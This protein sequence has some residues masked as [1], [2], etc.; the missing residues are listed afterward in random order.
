MNR[1]DLI[2]KRNDYVDNFKQFE[3]IRILGKNI[4]SCKISLDGPDKDHSNLL[5]EIVDF[6]KN[7]KTRN[8][9]QKNQK[10]GSLDSVDGFC[11]GR[12]M[13]LNALESWIFLLKQTEDTS[14]PCKS[15]RVTEVSDRLHT[16][17]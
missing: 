13:A 8:F 14:N 15:V 2:Y 5:L 17:I 11:E 3:N 12:K 1:G 7:T 10:I 16:K 6:N 9:S 4:S